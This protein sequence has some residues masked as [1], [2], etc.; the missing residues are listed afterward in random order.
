M[1]GPSRVRFHQHLAPCLKALRQVEP[2]SA[3]WKAASEFLHYAVEACGQQAETILISSE[4][5]LGGR[6]TRGE[7]LYPD[8]VQF[9]SSVRSVFAERR[10]RVILYV[11]RQ[12]RFLESCYVQDIHEGKSMATFEDYL[13]DDV[14]EGDLSWLHYA[15]R[16]ASVVG[17]DN[18]SVR[19]FE[20]I[21]HGFQPFALDFL[22]H[23]INP[24]GLAIP[25]VNA[26][27]S[28][29][30]EG[31]ELAR[32]IMPR[33]GR[34]AWPEFLTLLQRHLSINGGGT[35]VELFTPSQR[36]ALLQ[37]YRED[38]EQALAKYPGWCAKA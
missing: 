27:P 29:T 33:V 32:L 21:R 7:G 13:R 6:P 23:V 36:E 3:Q 10:L 38:L 34:D 12:D 18:L 20:S 24:K 26:N 11:R 25:E 9:L 31:L 17:A 1:L 14:G 2:S 35:R 5:L 4:G 28:L 30:S 22:Q 37:R 15:D 16:I 8:A 19:E